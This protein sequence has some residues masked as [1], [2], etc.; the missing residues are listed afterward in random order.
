MPNW[1]LNCPGS[2]H[3]QAPTRVHHHHYPAEMIAMAVHLVVNCNASLRCAAQAI[4]YYAELMEWDYAA[5][6]PMTVKTWVERCGLHEYDKR[7]RQG[8]YVVIMDESI[9]ISREQ[10]LLMLGHKIP[11][12][13]S[14]CVPLCHRDVEVLGMEVQR[15]WKGEEIAEV[16]K[17]RL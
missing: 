14:L 10:L 4:K 16:V 12:D 11:E 6:S 7:P 2:R 3:V 1:K 15:G 13:S 9:Q 8:R 5:P 17:R